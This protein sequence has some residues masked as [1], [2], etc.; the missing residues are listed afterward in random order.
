MAKS[1]DSEGWSEPKLSRAPMRPGVSGAGKA[2]V[3]E[4]VTP[5]ESAMRKNAALHAS[6]AQDYR[7]KGK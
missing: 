1:R 7:H 6:S 5:L 4:P 3:N 2:R